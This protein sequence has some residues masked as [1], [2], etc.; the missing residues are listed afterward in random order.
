MT[1]R[2]IISEHTVPGTDVKVTLEHQAADPTVA[3]I[4][5]DKPGRGS[6]VERWYITRTPGTARFVNYLHTAR[7]DEG[8]ARAEANFLWNDTVTR[9]DAERF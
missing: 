6:W 7:T 8:E 1:E 2:K 5:E 9:R 3:K 4:L